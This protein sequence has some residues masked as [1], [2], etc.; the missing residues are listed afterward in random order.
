M[1]MECPL[2]LPGF[3]FI[4]QP[5]IIEMEVIYNKKS[6]MLEQEIST[7]AEGACQELITSQAMDIFLS[8][9]LSTSKEFNRFYPQ[10]MSPKSQIFKN[11]MQ[12]SSIIKEMKEDN[13]MPT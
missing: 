4:M 1:L 10:T 2:Q 5:S 7:R 8:L 11:L 9:T 3:K 13:R 6:I 12:V